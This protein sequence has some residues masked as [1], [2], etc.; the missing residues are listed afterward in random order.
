MQAV[1]WDLVR[2]DEW[3]KDYVFNLDSGID[4]RAESI[5]MYQDVFRIHHIDKEKFQE[6]FSWYRA[7]PDFL[8]MVLDSID[9]KAQ[10]LPTEIQS[11]AIPGDSLHN[12]RRTPPRQQD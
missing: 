6:S 1:I 11:P 10:A 8:K 2:S 12:R 9:I 7:H 4:R 3:L 5:K